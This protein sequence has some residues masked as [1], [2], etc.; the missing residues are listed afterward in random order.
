MSYSASAVIVVLGVVLAARRFPGG[1]DWVYRVMSALASRKHNPDGAVYFSVGLSLSLAV[2][3]PTLHWIRLRDDVTR[4]LGRFGLRALRVGIVFG[5]MVG[6]ERL[7]FFHVS[8]IVRKGH[9]ALAAICFLS[10]YAGVL[11]LYIDR[12]RKGGGAYWPGVVVIALLAAIGGS[13]L[14]LY[15]DQRDLGWVDQDWR[16]KGVS[17]FL[18]FAFWQWLSA[19]ALWGAIGHLVVAS[20]SARRPRGSDASIVRDKS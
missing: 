18:S 8:Q 16:E 6:L 15:F 5:V 4:G 11:A 1:F 13:Q 19:A 2:L 9:E 10:L 7:A 3:W 20:P 12:L 17:I 14:V